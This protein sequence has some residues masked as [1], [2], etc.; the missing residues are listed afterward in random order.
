[1]M[2]NFFFYGTLLHK[3]VRDRV[4]GPQIDLLE[5]AILHGFCRVTYPGASVPVLFRS[6][7]SYVEGGVICNVIDAALE[8]LDRY[9]SEGHFYNRIQVTVLQDLQEIQAWVYVAP[10]YLQQQFNEVGISN[11][12]PWELAA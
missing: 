4:M 1:M 12:K 9:E 7:N 3:S 10:E 2:N 11:F 6:E 5:P 8:R